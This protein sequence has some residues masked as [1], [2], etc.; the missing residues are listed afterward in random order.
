MCVYVERMHQMNTYVR[1]SGRKTRMV[2]KTH[3]PK[4][5]TKANDI[6]VG[7]EIDFVI[8]VGQVV[9][10]VC[11]WLACGWVANNIAPKCVYVQLQYMTFV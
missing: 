9:V 5:T 10:C 2:C 8:N 11:V 6:I 7:C 1:K 3:I 4:T